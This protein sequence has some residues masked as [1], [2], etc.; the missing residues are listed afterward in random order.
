MGELSLIK[1]NRRDFLKK[2]AG[3]T[4]LFAIGS[5]P[6]TV[7][8]KDST[9]QLTILH[10]N[11]VHSRIEPFPMD[12][13][14]NQGLGGVAR[15]AA[16]VNTIRRE[17]EN[18]LLFDAGDIFQGTPYFNLYGGELEMQIM[19]NMGYDAA[20]M[21]NHDFDNGVA[22]FV[23]QLPHA[24]FPFLVSNYN[25][26]NTELKGKTHNYK[27]FKKQGLKIGVFGLGVELN[28]IVNKKNYGET[29]YLDPI[30]KA[31]EMASILKNEEHCDLVICLSH[32][33]YKYKDDKV[34]DLILAKSTRN[35]NLIIGGHTHTFMKAPEDIM[36]L[37]GKVTTVNQVGFAGINL[38][39]L[40]YFFNRDTG[41]H[42]MVSA[43]YPVH[44]QGLV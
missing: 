7:F 14:R 40:D 2:G 41:K 5:A 23:K 35:I 24:N 32:L 30:A 31:N 26:D 38:G 10:T 22:G 13:S 9:V 15:R 33:G 3:A 25:F 1:T 42:K 12:G 29:V 21:G 34:S 18:V 28:G 36:N 39:R 16:L 20:T 44:L 43:V 8:G 37:D 17:Q 11:D 4:A 19:S 6:L 27:I